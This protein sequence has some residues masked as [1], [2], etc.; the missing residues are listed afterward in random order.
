MLGA[1]CE[2]RTA[3][4][5]AAMSTAANADTVVVTADRMVDVLAGKTIANPVVVITDGRIASVGSGGDCRGRRRAR[6]ASTCRA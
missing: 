5:V 4:D 2:I 1:G 3:A 6:A